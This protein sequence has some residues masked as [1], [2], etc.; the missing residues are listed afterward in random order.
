VNKDDKIEKKEM[1][2]QKQWVKDM[3][4]KMAKPKSREEYKKRKQSVEPVFGIVKHIM[5]FRQF[6]LRGLDKYGWNGHW[7]WQL[8]T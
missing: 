5:G 4:E 2:F 1:P 6:L 8:T 3:S 7:F